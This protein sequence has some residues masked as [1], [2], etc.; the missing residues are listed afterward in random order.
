MGLKNSA[1]S[2]GMGGFLQVGRLT[3]ELPGIKG[4]FAIVTA[5]KPVPPTVENAS[6]IL[7]LDET[8]LSDCN[9]VALNQ[10]NT[11]RVIRFLESQMG[12]D[13]ES[14]LVDCVVHF[15]L[16]RYPNHAAAGVSEYGL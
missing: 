6:C 8:P 5:V 4:F 2:K 12:G 15:G 7:V 14:F 16:K 11:N 1:K 10:S 9:E 3:A 13:D